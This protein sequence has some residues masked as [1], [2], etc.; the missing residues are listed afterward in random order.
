MFSSLVQYA[1]QLQLVCFV[2][3]AHLIVSGKE[4]GSLYGLHPVDLLAR[5]LDELMRR[6]GAPKSAVEDVVCGMA[7]LTL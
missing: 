1:H 5:T 6:T 7:L 2:N 3:V 4:N